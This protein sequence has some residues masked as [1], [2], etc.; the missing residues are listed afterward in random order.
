MD[1]I[2]DYYMEEYINGNQN[3]KKNYIAPITGAIVF[4]VLYFF[5]VSA[6]VS[7]GNNRTITV[8]NGEVLSQ[9]SSSLKKLGIIRSE[10][11]FEFFVILSGG[12]K[13]IVP[14]DYFFENPAPAYR[15][16]QKLVS[17]DYGI[18]QVK[19]TLPEGQTRYE[20]AQ[21]LSKLLPYF[22]KEG[23][24]NQTKSDEGYLFPDTYFF[25]PN[26]DSA[27]VVETLK[28]TFIKKTE[29]IRT[30]T[31]SSG[32]NFAEILTMASIIEKEATGEN[33]RKVISGILWNRI[34]KKMPLQ[35]DATITYITGKSSKEITLDDLK[36]NS[37]YNTYIKQGLPPGPISNPGLASMDAVL[38]PAPT[39]YLYYLHDSKGNVYYATTFEEHKANK[40]KYLK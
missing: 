10:V 1:P 17:R 16:A 9:I 40:A 33:D 35:A 2:R 6:P 31:E 14:G 32:K 27:K 38:N 29:K 8:E 21:T 26:A 24:L 12:E 5:L 19:V 3:K 15:I 13:K 39:K 4:L 18:K 30:E 28:D 34:S 7:F 23:F 37:P 11:A 20:M 22:D 25:F 36:I